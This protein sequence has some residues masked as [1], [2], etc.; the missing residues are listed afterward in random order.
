MD[1]EDLAVRLLSGREHLAEDDARRLLA[2]VQMN[3]LHAAARRASTEIPCSSTAFEAGV[4]AVAAWLEQQTS[5]E[6]HDA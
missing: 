2:E 1:A 4:Y 6:Q 3:A 5:K